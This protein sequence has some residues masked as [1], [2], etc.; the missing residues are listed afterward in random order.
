MSA[1]QN[2]NI[3]YVFGS[4]NFFTVKQH[5]FCTI[6]LINCPSFIF[7]FESIVFIDFNK[8]FKPMNNKL[9]SL[10]SII[11]LIF[12]VQYLYAEIQLAKLVRLN[13]EVKI[14]S[15]LEVTVVTQ[16]SSKWIGFHKLVP[17]CFGQFA[18]FINPAITKKWPNAAYV[19]GAFKININNL[20]NFFVCWSLV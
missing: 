4:S 12:L 2:W 15:S 16:L 5:F 6:E 9:R 3:V 7:I 20:A 18:V 19:F 1:L 17:E 11:V 14:S 13:H 10:L 8:T